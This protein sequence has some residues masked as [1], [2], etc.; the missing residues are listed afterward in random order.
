M[1]PKGQCIFA[2]TLFLSLPHSSLS[3]RSSFLPPC[4]LS[5]L[6]LYSPSRP[7]SLENFSCRVAKSEFGSLSFRCCRKKSMCDIHW[8]HCRCCRSSGQARHEP[9][10]NKNQIKIHKIKSSQQRSSE[11]GFICG[12]YCISHTYALHSFRVAIRIFV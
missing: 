4:R 12:K 11:N 2:T 1:I 5:S 9:K 3:A 10:R 8:C 7:F 6:R